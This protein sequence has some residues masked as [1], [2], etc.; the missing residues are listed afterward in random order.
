MAISGSLSTASSSAILMLRLGQVAA[1]VL[2]VSGATQ[3]EGT[4]QVES[5][6]DQQNWKVER[7][8]ANTLLQFS[9]AN[10]AEKVGP[11]TIISTSIKN[12]DANRK[13]Y[14]VTA[15]GVADDPVVYSITEDATASIDTIV[16]DRLGR[17]MFGVRQDG[18]IVALA[19][20]WAANGLGVSSDDLLR[21]D[22]TVSKADIIGTSALQFGHAQGYPILTAQGADVGHEFV[23]LTLVAARSVAAYTG[24]G[25]ITVNVEGGGAALTGV[26][27]AANSLG[28]AT[29]KI[30]FFRPL[31]AAAEVVV[32]NKGFNLVAASAFTD[33]GTAAGVLRGRLYYRLHTLGLV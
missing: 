10:G 19:K 31:A 2:S 6:R 22:F 14:R 18:G 28:A 17:P 5:S 1:V 25:N 32:A 7:D 24:G 27:S 15:S 30:G 23:G 11:A 12:I 13:F 3:F 9:Y 29:N 33:P 26:L 4:V 8:I 20:L 21:L 16:V